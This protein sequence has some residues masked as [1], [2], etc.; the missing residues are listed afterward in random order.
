MTPVVRD[1]VFYPFIHARVPLEIVACLYGTFDN[2]LG[3]HGKFDNILRIVADRILINIQCDFF[4]I[5]PTFAR[6]SSPK[7]PDIENSSQ[8]QPN[9]FDERMHAK[10]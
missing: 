4:I 5:F 1:H 8:K 6:K 10:A 9:M 2:K 3:I 7:F